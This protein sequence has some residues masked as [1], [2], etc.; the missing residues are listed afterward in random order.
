M[1]LIFTDKPG[2]KMAKSR[3]GV[4]VAPRGKVII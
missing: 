2:G 4:N 1:P 3:F